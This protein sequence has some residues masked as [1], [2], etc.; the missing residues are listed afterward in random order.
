MQK[1]KGERKRA[2][3]EGLQFKKNLFWYVQKINL[4][5]IMLSLLLLDNYV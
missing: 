5:Q 3:D 2:W 4:A 1:K